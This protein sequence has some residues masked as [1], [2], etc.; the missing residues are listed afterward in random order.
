MVFELKYHVL[1]Y[2]KFKEGWRSVAVFR[3]AWGQMPLSEA[4]VCHLENSG[5]ILGFE[6]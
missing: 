5:T 2:C 1:N 6:I 3:G 4:F